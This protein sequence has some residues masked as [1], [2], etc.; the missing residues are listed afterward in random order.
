[1]SQMAALGLALFCVCLTAAAQVLLKMGMSSPAIQ[2]AMSGGIRSVYWLALTSP[3]IWGGMVC[4]GA[5]AGLWLL[6]LGKL[7]VSM[8]YPLISLGVVLTTLAG[9]FILG[10][11]VSIYKVLGVSLV[12]AGVLVL[13]VKN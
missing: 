4:F 6:V 3:L 8:A 9:I 13:S 5:S 11:S 1:M 2:H 7:D 10:E 12:I